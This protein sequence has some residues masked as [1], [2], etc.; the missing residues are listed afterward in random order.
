[1]TDRGEFSNLSNADRNPKDLQ[2][3]AH[4]LKSSAIHVAAKKL[5]EMAYRLEC[6]GVK[7]HFEK[8]RS[9]LSNPPWLLSTSYPQRPRTITD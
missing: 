2:L 5:V 7:E 4:R 8:V 9:F 1:M 3:Y 6:A